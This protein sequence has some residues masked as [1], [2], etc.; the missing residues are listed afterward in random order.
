MF[1][2]DFMDTSVD[3]TSSCS[4]ICSL[5]TNFNYSNIINFPWLM[6]YGEKFGD[7]PK[8]LRQLGMWNIAEKHYKLWLLIIT[9]Y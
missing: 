8:Y 4:T 6:I 9:V 1:L 5:E 7:F 3:K 2:K